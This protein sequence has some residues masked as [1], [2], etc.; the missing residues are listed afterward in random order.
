MESLGL[1]WKILV[2][3]I[4]NF[5]VLYFVLKKILYKPLMKA[6]DE[7][8]KKIRESVKKSEEIENR[9]QKIEEK[10]LAILAKAREKAKTEKQEII[11][12]GNKEKEV[13]IESAKES[14]QKVT[15]KALERLKEKEKEM[16]DSVSD[17]QIEKIADK[18]YKKMSA[19][20]KR[21]NFPILKEFIDNA[22]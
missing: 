21:G 11:E 12:L 9:L 5:A 1:D 16:A 4:L 13:I 3:Q 20:G 8:N 22:K 10:E 17:K 6:L 19:S 15:E 2:A 18:L 7:R 14:A